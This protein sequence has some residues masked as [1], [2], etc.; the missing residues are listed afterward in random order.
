MSEEII[1]LTQ[2]L[3]NYSRHMPRYPPTTRQQRERYD[4][5]EAGCRDIESQMRQAGADL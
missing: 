1:Q 4:E 2:Q 5:W 3:R